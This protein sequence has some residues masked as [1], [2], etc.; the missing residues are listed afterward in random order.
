M[1]ECT[2]ILEGLADDKD[3]EPFQRR[4]VTLHVHD[5]VSFA[6]FEL[7]WEVT[8]EVTILISSTFVILSHLFRAIIFTP[9][10]ETSVVTAPNSNDVCLL[11]S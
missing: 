1:K 9:P 4:P 6:S 5:S 11:D 2:R 10:F 8:R 7:S 3:R